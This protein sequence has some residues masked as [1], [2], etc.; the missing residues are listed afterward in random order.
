MPPRQAS[1][2]LVEPM[3][4]AIFLHAGSGFD[5]FQTFE[6]EVELCSAEMA[7]IC[8]AYLINSYL[9]AAQVKEIGNS[10][11]D[12]ARPRQRQV[13]WWLLH[14]L[15]GTTTMSS[16]GSTQI[17]AARS[18]SIMAVSHLPKAGTM[19]GRLGKAWPAISNGS[20]TLELARVTSELAEQDATYRR[21]AGRSAS[22]RR[23][24][25]GIPF[26]LC[27]GV[28]KEINIVPVINGM[29]VRGGAKTRQ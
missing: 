26:V 4:C 21:D 27:A 7:S 23:T 18:L 12:H 13:L 17:Y 2:L 9:L 1:A 5:C 6:C 29:R 28:T 11:Q 3:R 14:S 15:I 25:Q 20:T 24:E 10:P 22:T 16:V 8:S 19:G